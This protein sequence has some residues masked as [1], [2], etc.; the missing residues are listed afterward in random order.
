M[1]RGVNM[2]DIMQPTIDAIPWHDHV[3]DYNDGNSGFYWDQDGMRYVL[4]HGTWPMGLDSMDMQANL[5]MAPVE[6]DKGFVHR[7]YFEY[8]NYARE[9][10]LSSGIIDEITPIVLCG[11]SLGGA[12]A[13]VLGIMLRRAHYDIRQVITYATPT[14]VGNA[15]I[16]QEFQKLFP[17]A[18]NIVVGLDPVQFMFLFSWVWG[19]GGISKNLH[20]SG[21]GLKTP[22]DCHLPW[23][24]KD[25]IP[26]PWELI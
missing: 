4:I 10:L 21:K 7:G 18:K 8:A 17:T 5:K 25:R 26:A 24:I 9:H 23:M 13:Q 1:V 11:H 20:I 16:R 6:F 2:F 12:V 3:G 22:I 19:L 15:K 14:M